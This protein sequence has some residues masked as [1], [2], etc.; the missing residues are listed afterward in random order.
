MK[1]LTRLLAASATA[2]LLVTGCS[3]A[4]PATMV[5]EA[6]YPEYKSAEELF[7]QATLVVEA[8]LSTTSR[9]RREAE[10][11]PDPSD[12]DPL[13]NPMAGAPQQ[14]DPSAAAPPGDVVTVHDAKVLK[15]FKGSAKPGQTVEVKELGGTIDG[16]KYEVEHATP[17]KGGGSYL[18]FLETYADSPAAMLNSDQAQYAV[19]G[20]GDYVALPANSIKLTADDVSRLSDKD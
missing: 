17:L 3:G 4:E 5:I 16:V 19:S 11:V 9:V 15:V 12:T 7:A 20:T 1:A 13:S 14:A 8:T 2:A 18:L 6:E 10:P